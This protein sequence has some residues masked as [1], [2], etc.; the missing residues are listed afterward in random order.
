M[1]PIGKVIK[2]ILNSLEVKCP[3]EDCGKTM[4]L[5]EYEK[6]ETLCDLPKCQNEKCR[7][8][9]EQ[10]IEFKDEEGSIHKFCCDM[11]KYSFI[12]QQKT[13]FFKNV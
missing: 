8:G 2:N 10:L 3:N 1:R 9:R 6:H 12:F 7:K 5:E 13:K 11:C 4:T